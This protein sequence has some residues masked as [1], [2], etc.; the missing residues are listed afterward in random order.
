MAIMIVTEPNP[1]GFGDAFDT[2]NFSIDLCD[3]KYLG[4]HIRRLCVRDDI[5]VRKPDVSIHQDGKGD[6]IIEVDGVRVYDER[7][8]PVEWV[9]K[10]PRSMRRGRISGSYKVK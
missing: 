4:I 2:E 6:L 7:V 9:T 8:H 5:F 3:E 10:S 1:N